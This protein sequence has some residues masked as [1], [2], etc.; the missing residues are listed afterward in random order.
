MKRIN[1][2]SI[3]IKNFLSIGELPIDVDFRTGLNVIT[4]INKDKE[5]SKNG[6]GKSAIADA[7]Y[8][9][10]FG[11][12]LRTIRVE[13]IP[14]WKTKEQCE[15]SLDFT[16]IENYIEKEY[17]IVRTLNPSRVHLLENG[18]NISRTVSK[19]NS[20][21]KSI[22]GTTPELFEQSVIMSL[23]QTEPFLAKK[24]V[25]KRKFIEGIFKLDVFSEM[26]QIIRHDINETNRNHNLEKARNDEIK[27][28]LMVYRRQ[29]TEHEKKKTERI[30]L[31]ES[32]RND[33]TQ[34]IK[35]LS[36]KLQQ[37]NF[38]KQREQLTEQITQKKKQDETLASEIRDVIAQNTSHQ[39]SIVNLKERLTELEEIGTDVC[40]TCKRPFSDADKEQ[41]ESTKQQYLQN[42]KDYE[43]KI[44]KL[45]KQTT[46]LEQQKK[47][48]KKEIDE[49]ISTRHQSELN[50]NENETI[51]QRII[52]CGQWNDQIKI[53]IESLNNEEPPNAQLIDETQTRLEYSQDTLK[54]LERTQNTLDVAKF[55]VSDEGVKS[56]IVKKMLQMLNNRLN[57][58][59]QKLD[60]NC[61]CVF[62]EFF[63]ETIVN[64]KGKPVSYFNFSGGERKRIDLA[65]LF[66]FLD[67]RRLQSNISVNIS[68]YDELLDT[69][70]DVAGIEN[71]LEILK[72][73]IN[74]YEEAVYIISH[75]NQ[76]IK[77]AT[78]D[79][80]YLEKEE[81]VTRRLPY[82]TAVQ[83]T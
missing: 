81:E 5:D 3:K 64:Q 14:N 78:G 50:E 73:R 68:F 16:V 80:I 62:N 10:L 13:N 1:F 83:A 6:V 67:I 47:N 8:F 57:Y 9:A 76:A 45:N 70:L 61:V 75:K 74:D 33:N 22:I 36:K 32:R 4:G 65:M 24:P 40:L 20:K 69:S 38:K 77:H 53:D 60:A 31:L 7:I 19:T 58:Y 37:T 52:Q 27:N 44:E 28:N 41:H 12:P 2:K 26:L 25:T 49:L 42:I 66:T 82:G 17:K 30:Q 72:E 43:D 46:K 21:I 29:Q 35:D 79:I 59:L 15:I 54:K 34:E 23:N 63:E 51:K 55:V 11:T 56:F 39:T 71:V 18:K 48:I